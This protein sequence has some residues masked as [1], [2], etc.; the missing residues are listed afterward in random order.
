MAEINV[1]LAAN[2]GA[3]S[4]QVVSG[5]L[6]F[7]N[8][9]RLNDGVYQAV[10]DSPA[11][12]FAGNGAGRL[13][14]A[15]SAPRTISRIRA[16]IA[17]A[18]TGSSYLSWRLQIYN[19]AWVN[20]NNAATPPTSLTWVEVSGFWTNVTYVAAYC[21]KNGGLVA[22]FSVSELE[23]FANLSDPSGLFIKT[24]SGIVQLARVEASPL[25]YRKGG[26]TYSLGLVDSADAAAS[27]LR[28]KTSAGIRAVQKY[29]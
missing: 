5:S 25:K 17:R 20:V 9:A 24:A 1:A 21:S 11:M 27:P 13:R 23:A 19:G 14:I 8:V 12:G 15:L 7:A 29:E 28:I 18:G 2:G 16:R 3:P 22:T 6:S 26:V 10:G 4:S